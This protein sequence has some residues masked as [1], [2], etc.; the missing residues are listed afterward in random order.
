MKKGVIVR[1]LQKF[2]F[3][4]RLKHFQPTKYEVPQLPRNK[5]A[6]MTNAQKQVIQFPRTHVRK[7]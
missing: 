3:L 1:F 4:V 6:I 7:L 2:N 5:F